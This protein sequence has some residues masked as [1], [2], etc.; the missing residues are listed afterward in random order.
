VGD[1]VFLK[2]LPVQEVMRFNIRGKLSLRNIGPYDVVEKINP[3]ACRLDLPIE[4]EHL[5]NIFHIHISKCMLQI[6][7]TPL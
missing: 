3:V 2:G 5:Q 1:K 7:I 4:Q 6:Q